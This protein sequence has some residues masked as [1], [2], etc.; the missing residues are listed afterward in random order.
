MDAPFFVSCD[1]V[2]LVLLYARMYFERAVKVTLT[3]TQTVR[4]VII[5]LDY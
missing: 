1:G 5:L 4:E 2:R 3:D